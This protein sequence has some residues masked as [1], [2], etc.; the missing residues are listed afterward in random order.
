MRVFDIHTHVFPDAIAANTLRVLGE[1]SGGITPHFDGTR[2]GMLR[3]MAIDG[4]TASLNCPIATKPS[5][6]DTILGWSARQTWPL[7]SLGSLH[8]DSPDK[9]AL[10][11]KARALGLPGLKLH[12]EY[13]AFGLREERVQDLWRACEEQEM[14]VLLHAGND[15]AFKPP[16]RC[17]ALDLV[18]LARTYPRL[19]V[20]AAH[21]G[22]WNLW[23]EMEP[24]VGTSICLDLSMT[25]GF[26]PDDQILETARRHGI[27]KVLFGSDTPWDDPVRAL[28]NLRAVGFSPAEMQAICWDNATRLLG[29]PPE[30]AGCP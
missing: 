1:A 16:C 8:P 14:L 17:P 29:I 18:W 21:F 11:A 12:P 23:H 10:V 13:Q 19:K 5:Q 27:D 26:H 2:A 7:I 28:D 3:Q 6:V 24:L 15:I 9:P 20:I 30:N 4:I 22:G 25:L